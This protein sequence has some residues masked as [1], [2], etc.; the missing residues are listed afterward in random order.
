MFK[1]VNDAKKNPEVVS[2]ICVLCDKHDPY[3]YIRI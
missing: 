2:N 1:V 3:P